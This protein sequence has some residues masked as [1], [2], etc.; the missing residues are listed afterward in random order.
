MHSL[1]DQQLRRLARK[2]LP[3]LLHTPTFEEQGKYV[4]TLGELRDE[5]CL[6]PLATMLSHRDRNMRI[7]AINAIREINSSATRPALE[8]CLLDSDESVRE[9]ARVAIAGIRA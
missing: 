1:S 8:Q 3:T 2:L 6:A 7:L 9:A 5:R 4:V